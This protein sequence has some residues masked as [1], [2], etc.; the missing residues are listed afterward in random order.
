[1]PRIVPDIRLI[2]MS[3]AQAKFYQQVLYTFFP[4]KTKKAQREA[5]T[6]GL[7]P[8]PEVV[9]T[10]TAARLAASEPGSVRSAVTALCYAQMAIDDPAVLGFPSIPS[11][12]TEALIEML[13]GEFKSDKV[14]IYTRFRQ[15]AELLVARLKKEGIGAGLITGKTSGMNRRT[16]LAFAE[17]PA[18]RVVCITNAGNTAL[19]LQA[20]RVVVL[21]DLPWSPGDLTQTVGRARRKGSVHKLL[22]V[23]FLG[24]QQTVDSHT[25]TLLQKKEQ[26]TASTFADTEEILKGIEFSSQQV[27]VDLTHAQATDSVDVDDDFA[28][29]LFAL[30]SPD[31]PL[32]SPGGESAAVV[33]TV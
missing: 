15:L 24:V 17:D 30:T 26:L 14:L 27:T 11:A 10:D 3:P 19:D 25:L 8:A 32:P 5:E 29:Q 1:M 4:L 13:Q 6:I 31:Q 7:M 22:V 16:Q 12:K 18:L 2:D 23:V 20:A 33:A 21:F 9:T 28:R